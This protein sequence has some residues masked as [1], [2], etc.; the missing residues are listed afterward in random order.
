MHFESIPSSIQKKVKQFIFFFKQY[1]TFVSEE[2]R[3]KA[4]EKE[5]R[6]E[7][8][9]MVWSLTHALRSSRIC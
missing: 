6:D 2:I 9:S 8:R 4:N 1:I 5:G 3:A 7:A